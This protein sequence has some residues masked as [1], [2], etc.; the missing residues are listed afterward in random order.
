MGAV[1]FGPRNMA[2]EDIG[3]LD[4]VYSLIYDVRLLALDAKLRYEGY[5]EFNECTW[6]S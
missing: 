4:E 5:Y 6:C 3:F 2:I 1:S